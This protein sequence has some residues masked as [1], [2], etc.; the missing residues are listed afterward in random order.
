ML[1]FSACGVVSITEENLSYALQMTGSQPAR[2]RGRLETRF[3]PPTSFPGELERTRLLEGIEQHTLARVI[4]FSGPSGYGKTTTLAQYARRHPEK[5]LWL[6]L[7]EDDKDPR[8]FLRSVAQACKTHGVPMPTWAQL[9]EHN[10]SRDALLGAITTDLND[11]EDDLNIILDA[12]ESLSVESG[13]V[14][15]TLLSAVGEGHRFFLAQHDEG[16]FNAAPFL[17][18]GEALIFTGTTLPFTETEA[19]H[20]AD[21]LGE[22]NEA[23]QALRAQY[24]GWPAAMMLAIHG[25]R[26]NAPLPARLLVEQL[27][28]P[29]PAELKDTLLT[30]A[31]KETWSPED[32]PMLPSGISGFSVIQQVGVPLTL[33]GDQRFLPHDVVRAFLR[34]ELDRNPQRAHDVY[35]HFAR[36][37]EQQDLPYQALHWFWE[38]RE[39]ADVIRLAE[40]LMP[41]W[42]QYS[43]WLLVRETLGP[44]TLTLLSPVLQALMAV[45]LMETGEGPAGKVIA[46]RLIDSPDLVTPLAYFALT[47]VAFRAGDPQ[48]AID[49]ANAGLELAVHEVDRIRL[50]RALA[51]A[52]SSTPR[53]EEGLQVAT[54]A[55]QRAEAFGDASALLACISIKAYLLQRLKQ[56]DQSLREY[57]RAYTAGRHLGFLNR[58]VPLLTHLSLQYIVIG[59]L[60]EAEAILEEFLLLCETRY[61]LGIPMLCKSLSSLRHA[62]GQKAQAVAAGKRAFEQSL[63]F[64]DMTGATDSLFFFV[65][66]EILDGKVEE[67][68]RIYDKL[69]LQQS[70]NNNYIRISQVTLQAYLLFARGQVQ[71]SQVVSQAFLATCPTDNLPPL[72]LL[73]LNA[74]IARQQGKLEQAH[75]ERCFAPCEGNLIRQHNLWQ[76]LDLFPVL[77][78]T[79]LTQGWT[80]QGF[81]ERHQPAPQVPLSRTL[82]LRTLGAVSLTLNGTPVNF[83]LDKALQA[84]V[85]VLLEPGAQQDSVADALWADKDLRRGRQSARSARLNLNTHLQV[86]QTDLGLPAMPLIVTP[87]RGRQNSPW[88]LANHFELRCD[89]QE[90]L[91]QADP[92]QVQQLYQGLFLPGNDSEWAAHWRRNIDDHV[93]AILRQ[94]MNDPALTPQASLD[95]LLMIARVDPGFQAEQDLQALALECRDP[96]VS[97]TAQ[98]AIAYIQQGEWDQ[99]PSLRMLN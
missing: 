60:G 35:V 9:D 29:L 31:I 25:Q 32:F 41:Q 78:E 68:Q 24:Q 10:D 48:A 95:R 99:L 98:A 28:N 73:V 71:E 64:D 19:Q 23:L 80:P 72:N 93:A 84:L 26:Q 58:L 30:L 21:Q 6:R 3:S 45:A 56:Y 4:V 96:I 47:L 77:L 53:L 66:D 79:V 14:L 55:V 20:L 87:G 54:E 74:E 12:G 69:F 70:S 82:H 49:Y 43:D 59:R 75:L 94:G 86:L 15:S 38:G 17:A 22:P 46:L 92:A 61:P 11:H 89:A 33:L 67:A 76:I 81:A 5:T 7:G 63:A 37:L 2:R 83:V 27:F 18:R 40:T 62:Q 57:E 42:F 36:A 51:A 91:M 65:Y 13:R 34:A 39:L 44:V 8:F 52:L 1:K 16:A 88:K 85:Y 90:I 97:R 50:L